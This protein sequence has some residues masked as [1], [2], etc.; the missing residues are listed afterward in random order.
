MQALLLPLNADLYALELTAV[1]EVVP[2]PEVTPLP[3]APPA[4]LGVFNLRGEVVPLF[5]TARLLGLA[6]APAADQVTVADTQAGPAGLVAHGRPQREQLGDAAGP[7]ALAAALGRYAI[8]DT[9]VCTLLD[10][11]RLLARAREGR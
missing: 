1:R 9:L 5:D 10:V 2:A 3:G 4:L 7:A 6:S 8:G 11:E